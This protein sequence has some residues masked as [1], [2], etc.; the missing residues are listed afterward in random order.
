MVVVVVAAIVVLVVVVDVGASVVLLVV[1]VGFDRGTFG[2]GGW[3]F[4]DVEGDGAGVMGGG[5]RSGANGTSR[6]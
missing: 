5:I 2:G 3:Y 6:R 4:T 1:D